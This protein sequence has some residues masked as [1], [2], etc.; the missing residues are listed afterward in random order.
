M[1]GASFAKHDE[2]LVDEHE[3]LV[4]MA[5]HELHEDQVHVREA[6]ED[7]L[8]T[9]P[10]CTESGPSRGPVLP[11]L[12]QLVVRRQGENRR[13]P[14]RRTSA[15]TAT[16][17]TAMLSI[18]IER[19]HWPMSGQADE[20][21]HGQR[22]RFGIAA[23]EGPH[24]RGADVVEVGREPGRPRQ[25]V[26]ALGAD[27]ERF[28]EGH[29]VDR[30]AVTPQVGVVDLVE[31]VAA[32]TRAAS[33]A[34]VAVVPS[35]PSSATTIDFAT[36]LGERVEHVPLV[37]AVVRAT[38]ATR[39]SASKLPANTPRRSNTARSRRLEQRVRP[40][41]RGPQRL[42]TLDRGRAGRR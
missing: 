11:T 16:A 13:S 38:T 10:S 7:R 28:G 6:R 30:E 36:R 8:A 34:A 27:G 24:H 25:V 12:V 3:R 9:M 2:T 22:R 18:M 40:V 20:R 32:R 35:G 39:G 15:T 5:D 42:V 4:A 17:R 1:Y 33:R 31:L 26:R 23:I 29:D 14:L 21:A 41:D 37:D 19:F